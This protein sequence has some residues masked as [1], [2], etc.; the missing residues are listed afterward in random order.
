MINGWTDEPHARVTAI[1]PSENVSKVELNTPVSSNPDRP[2][3]RV[4]LAEHY[5]PK[6]IHLDRDEDPFGNDAVHY[7]EVRGHHNGRYDHLD[8][9]NVYDLNHPH[10]VLHSSDDNRLDMHRSY[11]HSD[12]QSVYP[13]IK[14]LH[15]FIKSAHSTPTLGFVTGDNMSDVASRRFMTP[16]DFA[17][18]GAAMRAFPAEEAMHSVASGPMGH[19]PDF[20]ILGESEYLGKQLPH[21][22]IHVMN[23]EKTENG[24]RVH[25]FQYDPSEETLNHIV[26]K[27]SEYA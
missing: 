3:R 25:H 16:E 15:D 5:V 27:E 24:Q 21:G 20:S 13:H 26:T 6:T 10:H 23:R 12:L 18:F 2:N 7:W 17:R 11:H 1:L 4:I 8:P 19:S 14:N 9:S 22:M